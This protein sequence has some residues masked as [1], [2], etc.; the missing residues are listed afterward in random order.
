MIQRMNP[1][2]AAHIATVDSKTALS[3][4]VP[5][6]HAQNHAS[7]VKTR[8]KVPEAGGTGQLL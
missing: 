4:T 5:A 3:C 1:A 6:P 2:A 8:V 7:Q